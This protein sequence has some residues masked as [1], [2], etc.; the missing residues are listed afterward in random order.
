MGDNVLDV[1]RASRLFA[2]VAQDPGLVRIVKDLLWS[3]VYIHQ[4]RLTQKAP[5]VGR[6]HYWHSDFEVWHAVD[7]MPRMRAVSCMLLLEEHRLHSGPLLVMPASHHQFVCRAEPARAPGKASV[8]IEPYAVAPDPEV[9][10]HWARRYGITSVTG[11]PGDLCILDC[12]IMQGSTTNLTPFGQR[13]LVV[14][15][16]SVENTLEGAPRTPSGRPPSLANPDPCAIPLAVG[17]PR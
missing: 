8:F 16:N 11:Q 3:D 5:L 2:E 12:N 1:Q 9:L 15:Y 10:A 14:C 17:G 6:E 4:V 13:D 7:G